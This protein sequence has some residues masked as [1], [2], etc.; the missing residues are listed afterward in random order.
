ME[1]WS[2][3]W[4]ENVRTW[5]NCPYVPVELRDPSAF[6]GAAALDLDWTQLDETTVLPE[7]LETTLSEAF[8]G[9]LSF[10][11]AGLRGRMGVGL[12][13]MNVYTVATATQGVAAWL[14]DTYPARECQERGI[15]IGYDTRHHS[16]LFAQVAA[17]VMA[18]NGITAHLFESYC[19]TPLLAYAIRPL[20]TLAGIMVTASHNPKVYNGYKLYGEDGIQ[21]GQT[22]ADRIAAGIGLDYAAKDYEEC[23]QEQS[24]H[25]VPASLE[26]DYIEKTVHLFRPAPEP[27]AIRI[28]YTPVHGTGAKLVLPLLRV[29]GFTE[30]LT[31]EEQL[32]PDGDFPTAPAPNPEF[33][34]ATALLKALAEREHVDLALATDPDADRLAVLLPDEKGVFH[35]LTGNQI[36]GLLAHYWFSCLEEDQR[37]PERPALVK[38]I[39]TDD[40]GAR[41]AAA[42]GVHTEETLTGFK[43]ICGKIR[44]FEAAK[45]YNYVMGYEESIGFALGKNV[46]DKDGC[47]AALALAHAAAVYRSR[48]T[49]L[50]A[51]LQELFAE[52]GYIASSALNLVRE[53][54]QG[55]ELMRYVMDRY[56]LTCPLTLGS[57]ALTDYDDFRSGVISRIVANGDTRVHERIGELT[58]RSSNVLR[59]RFADGSWYALR[60]SGTEPKLKVYIYAPGTTQALAEARVAEMQAGITAQLDALEQ[61]FH[62]RVVHPL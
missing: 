61:Q 45:T 38:S 26:A 4:R 5:F 7:A 39:V 10:G 37:M 14:K 3:N 30:V 54:T 32:Q 53:G 49:T 50:W 31:V 46:L 9:P 40:F 35:Q 27:Q 42:H 62:E 12:N 36:G 2:Q 51:V 6:E 24:I 34:Q 28:A 20:H 29:A 47:S 16:K 21:I 8:A 22:E 59:Y 19:Q 41:V 55:V 43:D 1:K 18:A 56:R 13:R 11:T 17:C 60:P 58:L 25:L 33:T 48:Q 15:V 44:E 52:H 23:L 57:V